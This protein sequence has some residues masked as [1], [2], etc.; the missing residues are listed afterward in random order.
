MIR[1]ANEDDIPALLDM[2]RRFFEISGYASLIR[3][4]PPSMEET[5]RGLLADGRGILMVAE[6]GR[7]VAGMAGGMVYPLYFSRSHMTGQELFWWIDPENRGGG[8]GPRLL[9]QMEQSAREKGA[10]SFVM[11][12][13]AA[14]R[15]ERTGAYYRRRGYAPMEHLYTR[16]L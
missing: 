16:E 3:F 10:C 12:A 8:L 5:L 14:Q 13:L 7:G 2:S 11:G 4:D 1:D 9:E 15:P 6:T